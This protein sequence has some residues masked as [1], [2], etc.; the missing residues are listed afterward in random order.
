M[1][2]KKKQRSLGIVGG[3]ILGGSFDD[4]FT[5]KRLEVEGGFSR[6]NGK[7]KKK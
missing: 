4:V 2:R 6:K 7:K 5:D 1:V 3:M